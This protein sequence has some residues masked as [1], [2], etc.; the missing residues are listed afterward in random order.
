MRASKALLMSLV[1]LVGLGFLVPS[2]VGAIEPAI[3][4]GKSIKLQGIGLRE[5]L[6][7]EL[8]IGTLFTEYRSLD[9]EI[10]A[11]PGN[12]KR[13]ELRIVTSKITAKRFGRLWAETIRINNPSRAVKSQQKAIIMFN[14]MFKDSLYRGDQIVMDHIPGEGTTIYLNGSELGQII[15]DSFMGLL[16]QTW[17][18]PRPPS[19]SFKNTI[20]GGYE[21]GLELLRQEYA[22]LVPT[23][24]RILE[25]A[26]WS[27]RKGGGSGVEELELIRPERLTSLPEVSQAQKAALARQKAEEERLEREKEEARKKAAREKAA[28]EEAARKKA[29]KERKRKAALAAK[30][31]KERE[32]KA[33]VQAALEKERQEFAKKQAA[34]REKAKREEQR[35]QEEQAKREIFALSNQYE[36]SLVEW[37]DKRVTYP[38]SAFKRGLEGQGIFKIRITRDGA[39]QMVKVEK[40]TR[41][42]LLDRE[43]VKALRRLSPFPPMPDDLPGSDFTFVTPVTFRR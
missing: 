41:S 33:A 15:S 31:K 14:D 3:I 42:Q 29:E 1:V 9:P 22:V 4:D 23:K 38:P 25:T 24:D 34:E 13:M 37:V 8:Y 7:E 12:T 26:D 18:G 6:S 35:K 20:L 39:V 27:R 30:K 5:Q 11:E 21:D 28:R 16:L 17:I 2:P 43:A 32:I 19:D 40:S 36:Q 10:L